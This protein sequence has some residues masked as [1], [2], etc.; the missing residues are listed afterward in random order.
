MAFDDAGSSRL[1]HLSQNISDPMTLITSL[2]E[3]I[4]LMAGSIK[5]G[6]HFRLSLPSFVAAQF[7][8]LAVRHEM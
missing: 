5:H 1:P 2:V 4:D 8:N 7:L 6:E 3:R